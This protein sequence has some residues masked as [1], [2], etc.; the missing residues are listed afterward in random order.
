ML[1]SNLKIIGRNFVMYFYPIPYII[2]TTILL[3]IFMYI[4]LAFVIGFTI[5]ELAETK[6]FLEALLVTISGVF[7][8][9]VIYI[10]L[11]IGLV[12]GYLGG[13]GQMLKVLAATGKARMS[14]FT[15]GVFSYGPKLFFGIV[16]FFL[17]ILLPS[18]WAIQRVLE[19][20]TIYD[21]ATMDSGWNSQLRASIDNAQSG[22][23]M[24]TRLIQLLTFLLLGFWWIACITETRHFI[25]SFY[26]S[27][28]FFFRNPI[29]ATAW[30]IGSLVS[31]GVVVAVFTFVL[32]LINI[33]P[34]FA[35]LI[36]M[37]IFT[38]FLMLIL[39]QV[40]KP[41]YFRK[42]NSILKASSGEIDVDVI[43]NPPD[44]DDDILIDLNPPDENDLRI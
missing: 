1:S 39:I 18:I 21:F 11:I 44:D 10:L 33:S 26:R 4:G 25:T 15:S 2:I 30:L 20:Y 3:F 23:Y 41:E 43:V 42:M 13:M 32:P 36:G 27:I 6:T 24:H 16:A 17:L 8:F 35:G 40:Y 14:D 38:P 31:F 34:D 5:I 37:Y 9:L 19:M 12:S 7:Y 28:L 29:K 22:I